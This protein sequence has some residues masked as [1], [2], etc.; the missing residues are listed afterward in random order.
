ML[1]SAAIFIVAASLWYTNLLS[2]DIAREEKKK[3]ELWASAYKNL[4]EADA[5][6]DIS[7][8]FEVIKDN[9]T[10]PVIL[11][12]EDGN[13]QAWR[14]IDS[15]KAVEQP[16]YLKRKLE[17]M[18][19]G[20]EPLKIELGT[21]QLNYIY[22]EDS[23]LLT[24]LKYY[25]FIQLGIIA[26]FLFIAYLAFSTSKAAEQ[27]QLWVGMAKETAHQLG[28]PI[29]SL[30]AWIEILNDKVKDEED[31]EIV[32]DIRK[33]VS[34]LEL[35]AERF[36]KI[37]SKPE[38]E[39]QEINGCLEKLYAYIKKRTS[40][41]VKL[42]LRV[43]GKLSARINPPLFEW[44]IENLLKNALDAISGKGEIIIEA[45]EE[46]KHIVIDIKDSGKGIP[47]SDFKTVFQT[48]YSTKK[49]GWGLG[50]TL[51]KRI[52]EQYHFGK[53]FVRESVLGE[54]TTFRIVLPK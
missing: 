52:I 11:A 44:V 24:Q 6:T 17:A 41:Q 28:T 3:V 46:H 39:E 42:E 54:G 21:G 14:N 43:Y 25:P 13:I 35:V 49:R 20:K 36:S 40:D 51:S 1:L 7:F 33:D 27:N 34:R 29:S 53:I 8:L 9:E 15:T 31:L 38:L 22:Y 16:D 37:G 23:Y 32:N 26:I 18:K 47:K 10:V 50:L 48:G 45:K 5:N 4:N 2:N 30:N 12:D 19:S